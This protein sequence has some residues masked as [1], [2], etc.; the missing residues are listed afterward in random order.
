MSRSPERSSSCDFFVTS[1]AFLFLHGCS[2]RSFELSRK[3][4]KRL[5]H[6]EVIESVYRRTSTASEGFKHEMLHQVV[7]YLLPH[8]NNKRQ[9]LKI[10]HVHSVSLVVP[11]TRTNPMPTVYGTAFSFSNF[12]AERST[13]DKY[14]QRA[15]SFHVVGFFARAASTALRGINTTLAKLNSRK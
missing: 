9:K 8:N 6:H 4:P 2:S 12:S 3:A 11:T 5:R 7:H 14:F 15:Q 13:A 1:L 10:L